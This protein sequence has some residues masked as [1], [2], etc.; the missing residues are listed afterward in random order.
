[1]A[2]T[3]NPWAP[4]GGDPWAPLD[5]NPW[6]EPADPGFTPPPPP[7]PSSPGY[8]PGPASD[9]G[10]TELSAQVDGQGKS[11]PAT[12]I[13]V[14][15]TQDVALLQLHGGDRFRSV[16]IGDSGPVE[17]GD[18]VVAVGNALALPGPETVTGGL[19]SAVHRAVAISDPTTGST[20]DL[21]GMFQT[22]AAISSGNSG[23][24]LVDTAGRVIAMNT[25]AASTDGSGET[26]TDVGFAIPINRAMSLARQI[27]SGRSSSTVQIGAQAITGVSVTSVACAD[28]EDG[29]LPLGFGSFGQ[30]FSQPGFYQAP[31]DEGAV[32]DGVG[33]GTPAAAAGVQVGDVITSFDKKSV[34]SPQQLTALLN[35][36][37]V[38]TEVTVGWVGDSGARRSARFPLVQGPN[39]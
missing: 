33:A 13:G 30:S 3:P 11:Y 7:P 25:A 22:S 39:L 38:G 17:V 31:T 29:C 5:A 26:A 1:M 24:P 20:E 32:V 6:A 36:L 28:G 14:D 12:V 23:G 8:G 18:Q 2:E 19:I 34:I 21:S 4:I 37:K 27:L 15:V 35:G 9:D 16:T 10:S